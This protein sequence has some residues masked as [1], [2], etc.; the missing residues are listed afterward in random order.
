MYFYTY[1]GFIEMFYLNSTLNF[2][3]PQVL[4]FQPKVYYKVDRLVLLLNKKEQLLDGV[5][6]KHLYTK[7]SLFLVVYILI[8]LF[9]Y[10]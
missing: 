2:G 5:H 1:F 8:I 9:M 4:V 6:I 10:V 7:L 3:I